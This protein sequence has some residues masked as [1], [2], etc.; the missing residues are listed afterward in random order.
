MQ[1]FN[2]LQNYHCSCDYVRHACI[3]VGMHVFQ[4]M[5]VRIMAFQRCPHPNSEPVNVLPSRQRG[6]AS[7]N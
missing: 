3:L 7:C 5:V 2:N 4:A 1:L 6:C